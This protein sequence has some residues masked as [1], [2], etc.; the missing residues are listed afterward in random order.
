[1]INLSPGAQ[2]QHWFQFSPDNTPSPA[3]PADDPWEIPSELNT[4]STGEN[5]LDE[6]SPLCQSSA[7]TNLGFSGPAGSNFYAPY[8]IDSPPAVKTEPFS[9]ASHRDEMLYDG[10]PATA[11]RTGSVPS[12][13]QS[14]TINL[15]TPIA[16]RPKLYFAIENSRGMPDTSPSQL[17][18]GPTFRDS[19]LPA[20]FELVGSRSN[21]PTPLL[22]DI[23]LRY[24]WINQNA[25]VV[26]RNIGE[27]AWEDIKEDVLQFFRMSREE[28]SARKRFHVWVRVGD[29]TK[30]AKNASRDDI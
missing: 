21:K 1:M 4:N 7:G 29:T 24:T 8:N 25:V 26:N 9:P 28:D 19:S 30:A 3:V 20:F 6:V 2:T 18:S 12:Q 23:T 16:E 15:T 5:I 10:L 14:V 11:Q 22:T 17:V 27:E 13:A